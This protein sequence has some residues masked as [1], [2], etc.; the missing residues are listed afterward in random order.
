MES[1]FLDGLRRAVLAVQ[2]KNLK[3]L[4]NTDCFTHD[5][6]RIVLAF[7]EI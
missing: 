2:H 6:L 5:T 7:C 3:K 4:T 1:H